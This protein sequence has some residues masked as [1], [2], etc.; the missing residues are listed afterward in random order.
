V[1]ELADAAVLTDADG[2]RYIVVYAEWSTATQTELSD[3]FDKCTTALWACLDSL[4]AEQVDMLSNLRRPRDPGAP[5]YFPIAPSAE[6][7]EALLADSCLD[8][9]LLTQLQI[10]RDC[11]PFAAHPDDERI[12]QYRSGLRQ[13]LVTTPDGVYEPGV[14]RQAAGRPP[15]RARPAA[16]RRPGTRPDATKATTPCSSFGR[17]ARTGQTTCS[18]GSVSARSSPA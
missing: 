16:A 15:Q 3:V 4:V 18:S 1:G 14:D 10:V 11:Q 7:F 9:I 13:L 6:D 12:E 5:R 2:T 8:G 17:S